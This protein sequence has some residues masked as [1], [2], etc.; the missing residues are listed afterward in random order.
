[1][2]ATRDSS[3]FTSLR[4]PLWQ[5]I[6]IAAA[7]VV[8]PIAMLSA[9]PALP[10]QAATTSSLT[11]NV[12]SA[13]TEPRAFSGAGVAKGAAIPNFTYMVNEDN[14][15][16]TAQRSPALGSGCNTLDTGYPGS[17]EW[18]SIRETPHSTSPIVRQGDQ[19]DFAG[20]LTLPNGRYLISVLSD[21]YK[22]DG[23]HFTVPLPDP[24]LVTVELQPTP[25]PDSTLRAQIFQDSA[26][27]NGTLDQGEPGLAGFTGHIADTLGEVQTDV[28]G[29]PLCTV[30]QGEDPISHVIP[31]AS[32]DAGMLPVPIPGS[33]GHCVSD[34]DGIL[35]MPHLGSNRYAL[36]ASAPPNQ[37]W[38]Q[39][40]TLEGNHDFD[41]WVMEGSTG[42]DTEALLAG[43]PVPGPIFGFVKP[44]NTLTAGSGHITGA[45]VNV[46]QYS[47]PKGGDYNHWLGLTGSKMGK[48][49]VNPWL[50]LSD[51][52]AGDQAVWVG[53][54]GTDGTFDI[55]GVPDG[56]YSLSWWDEPQNHFLDSVNVTVKNGETVKMGNLPDSGWWTEYD[57]YV[58]NDTN[59]NGVKD[60]GETGMP[61]FTLTM[62]KQDNSLMDRGTNLVTTDSTGYYHFES[63]Y[64]LS[65]WTVMENFNNSFYTTGVTYQAD[66]QPTPTTVKG[67]G[68]DV[69]VLSIIG[70][71]G[72]MD[73]GVHSYD[74]TGAN[75]IDPRNGGIVGS[76]S[77]DT[78]RN[79]LDPQYAASEDWQPGVSDVP[80][81]LWSTVDCGTTTAPCGGTNDAFELAPDGSLAKGKLLNTYL[82]EHWSRPTGCVAR[83][84][85]GKP[86]VH[87]ADNS[88]AFDENVLA[89]NQETSGEC[90]SSF[91]QGVQFGPY[92][93]DQGTPA[94]NFGA[95]VDGNYGFADACTG[96]VIATDPANPVCDGGT[97]QPLGSGDYLVKIA[98]PQDATGDPLYKVTSE[99]D[100]NIAN[101]DQIVPQVP[102]PACAGTLHT[103]DL[104][105]S[106]TDNYPAVVGD[107]TN[108][109]PVGVTVAASTAVSNP[110]F[111]GIGGSP[112]EGAAKPTCDT[113]LVRVNNGKSVVPMFN[114]FTDVPVPARL[115]GLIV[116]DINF[117]TDPRSTLFGEKTGVAFAPVGIYDFAN[118]LVT[119]VESDFNGAYDVLLPSTNHISCP[120]PSGVCANMYRFVGNDPGVPGHLNANYNPRYRSIA[121]EF[122]AFPGVTI[123][124]D[125]A[126]TQVGVY[127][128]SPTT[129]VNT[130]VT[131]ALDTATPQL[132][133]VSQPYVAAT[134]SRSFTIAG[135]GLGSAQGT[136]HVNLGSTTLD[137]TAW[138]DTSITASVPATAP[139]GAQQLTITSGNG[140]T[141]VNGLSFHVLGTG[142]NPAVREVGPG[143]TH[144]TI[145]AALD[146]AFANNGDDL[147]IVYPATPTAANPRG[148]YYENLVMASPVKLQGV[149][150]GGFQG[151]TFVPG[152][153]IDAGAFGG[154]T[155][156]AT[157]WFAKVG[158]L[159]WDGNQAVNDGEAI[160]VLASANATT[161]PGA[162]RQFT[163]GFTAAIDGFDI[164][165]GDQVG[166]PGNID[167]LTG[168][169]T[170]LPPNITTQGGAI[171][172]NAY[173]RSLQITNNVVQNNGGGYGTIRIGTPD[174]AAPNTSNHNENVRIANNRV[175]ANAGTNLAGGIG[176]FAGADG[177]EVSGNDICGNF[178][179]EYGGGLS[180]YG[181][182]PGGKIHHNRIYF[183]SSNDEG[184]AIMIAGQLPA[185]VGALSPGSGPVDIYANQIQANMAND[186]G[187]GI[188]FLMAGNFPMNVYNNMI[189]NNVSTHEGGGIG[190]N[191]APNVRVYNNT[192]MK[193]LTT[194]TAVTSDGQPAPAGLATSANSDQLQATLPAGSPTFSN[195]VSFNNI[196]WDNR[197][198][199]R[200]GTTVTGIGLTGAA[201]INNWDLGVADGT[202]V[203]APTNSV[204]QQSSASHA[205]TT[206]PTNSS[207]DPAVV[208]TYDVSV[209]FAT[210]RQNP[211]FVDATLVTLQAPPNLLGNYHLSACP[212]TPAC[213]LGAASTAGV[214][215]PA[216]D[217]D[218]Q[219]RPALGGF[220]SGADEF[221]A[222]TTPPPASDLYF[223]TTG[224]T[225]PPGVSGT[226]DDADIHVWNGTAFS[227]SIDMTAAPYNVPSSADTDGFSRVDATH[228]YASFAGNVTLPGIGTVADEDVV[229][230]DGSSWSLWF[231][232]SANGLLGAI[233]MGAISVVGNTL[234]FTTNNAAVPPGAGGTGDNADVYRWNGGS[235]YVRVLD[236]TAAPTNLPNSG[237]ATG[238]T[239]PN[240]DG[241]IWKDATHFYLSF[242]N[243][244]TTVPGVGAVDDEDVVYF[245]GAWSIYFNG[246]A[247]GL[248]ASANLDLDAISFATGALPPPPPPAGQSLYFSTQGNSNPPGV[249]G[250]ADDAD[251]YRWTGSTFGRVHDVTTAPYGLPTGA[252]VD[253]YDRVDDTHFYLSFT[254]QVTV[255]G[256]GNVQDEDVVY[257]NAGT[258][259]LYFDGSVHGLGGNDNL[260]LDAI[261]VVSG[262]L[263]FSTVGNANPPGVGGSADNGDIYSWNGTAY[264]RVIDRSAAPY[265]L[266]TN[267]DID[268]FV[269][270]DATHFYVSFSAANTTV[271]TLGAVQDEDVV[272]YNNGV[273]SVY[274]DG[275]AHGLGGNGDFNVD[276]FDV[277]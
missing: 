162:A 166:F 64:P 236:A 216:T 181:L 43:E 35:T 42:Y 161:A 173:A 87:A 124:T 106:K 98:I 222:T 257:F 231:D 32:L 5:R 250:T 20:G 258:W 226:A 36:T 95:A 210:W 15:G 79:E 146:A 118:R 198:G 128:G 276:A 107:G 46:K 93:T 132:L 14:T 135:T 40:T 66:N 30:Y 44:T 13:R 205:Y 69:S 6:V 208:S 194:A 175:I 209:S 272:Y 52:Q 89:P 137:V 262:I 224:N 217:F 77:Y 239:N 85:D 178:S 127:V 82:S 164:R 266:P 153:I 191:D 55:S 148:A 203:L 179:L 12:I 122:E 165:G 83:D 4:R 177:Y 22:I 261:S 99:T 246:G 18:T 34:A 41:A 247:H 241:L 171:F 28:Y 114:I 215:A 200:A 88:A 249:G 267:T 140:Q 174:L 117:S 126:P 11:L 223:S 244:T 184:G 58:F 219:A 81:E 260:D 74:S 234:F 71:G 255:P 155:A 37:T 232:G 271:P 273:W 116:D 196:F 256:L 123:P 26:T 259:S 3:G 38:I 75:G 225:N 149:G 227:R 270:V 56:N 235:S 50:S 90:I 27:T 242:S 84:V 108:G 157:A 16:T 159:T 229:Y 143:R 109:V 144:T 111:L 67:A 54:G 183:N 145:Q 233:D 57:G 156:L 8:M 120:T 269:R 105:G 168:G 31:V 142:Y 115:R 33:G 180:A 248:D 139:V 63:A 185:T 104:A 21:G 2:E 10:A 70:L 60:P 204:V 218:N 214:N 65:E 48:P 25:L 182:S 243:T 62:R 86:L 240:V 141:T 186:D 150:S 197:A 212:G 221:G 152:S 199:T 96:T 91:I 136:G 189:V 103:V 102:P 238:A 265:N 213:N 78:T 192:I 195:P 147:V 230:F 73:W 253:G 254:G 237:S 47:P 129:G 17:C 228:F 9:P 263:Y 158:G 39:T 19:S 268:G 112:Y 245:D 7:A 169:P 45:V 206:S 76:V 53:H 61:N 154:D 100:I 49:I 101:G 59:R 252:N 94:A 121:T 110:T 23:A 131:C 202:G 170:G 220:D 251:I 29:N 187:G 264:S 119:T 277:P 133:S 80:V 188:R 176:L 138:S 24:G 68:V 160:Y 275:T 201:D 134:G 163:S 211:A 172:A 113:K 92:P 193:N 125:L 190:I 97:F 72:T 274:F 51:L 167:A 207:A 151:T 130:A 1:M